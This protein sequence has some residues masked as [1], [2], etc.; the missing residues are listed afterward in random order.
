MFLPNAVAKIGHS[1]LDGSY[2][3]SGF[4][5]VPMILG[6][7][8]T[9]RGS[10]HPFPGCAWIDGQEPELPRAVID[11]RRRAAA[12]GI[13]LFG[14]GS[15][16]LRLV[17]SGRILTAPDHVDTGRRVTDRHGRDRF[18][19]LIDVALEEL[20]RLSDGRPAFFEVISLQPADFVTAKTRPPSDE[21]S[22]WHTLSTRCRRIP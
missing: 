7:N 9:T 18:A 17:C 10:S 2:A 8:I 15:P 11:E 16:G 3:S 13:P 4:V 21:A 19:D 1:R 22:G 6:V 20:I 12:L 5:T 14:R